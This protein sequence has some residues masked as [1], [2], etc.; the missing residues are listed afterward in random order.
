MK[1]PRLLA[2]VFGVL[3][4]ACANA[5]ATTESASFRISLRIAAPC[6]VSTTGATPGRAGVIVRCESASTPYQLELAARRLEPQ[7]REERAGEI[8]GYARATLT[9]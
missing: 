2:A 1:S 5:S 7:A 8:D 3:A 4:L 6:D 9:F